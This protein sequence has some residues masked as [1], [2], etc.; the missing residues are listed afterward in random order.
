MRKLVKRQVHC[1]MWT[2]LQLL[3]LLGGAAEAQIS[4]VGLSA[5][6]SQHFADENLIFYVPGVADTFASALAAGDFNGDGADDL[7]TGVPSHDNLG[8]GH[9]D[10]GIVVVRYGASRT[11][12][13]SGLATT[14]LSQV[15]GGEPDPAEDGDAFGWA[16][17]SCDFN[18]DGFD[19]LA[20]G[21]R[22]E[23]VGSAVDAGAVEIYYGGPSGLASVAEQ[24]LT[25]NSNGIPGTAETNDQF[26]MALGC[27][28]LDFDG[29]G[30]LAIG[31]PTETFEHS[32]G[33]IVGAGTVALIYGGPGGLT[34]ARTHSF[35]ED[36]LLPSDH[37]ACGE[38]FGFAL[39]FG[40]FNSDLYDDLVIGA[41]GERIDGSCAPGTGVGGFAYIQGGAGD[42]VAIQLM[43]TSS[44]WGEPPEIGDHVGYTLAAG[45]FDGDLN[46][47]LAVGVPFEDFSIPVIPDAGEV[48]VLYFEGGFPARHQIWYEEEVYGAGTSEGVD[49]FGL[50]LAAA[51][52]DRDGFSD[53]AI[54]HPGE[55]VIATDD[56]ALTVV[57]GS[58]DGLIVSRIRLFVEGNAGLPGPVTQS[59]RTFAAALAAGDFDGDGAADLAIGA[60]LENSA[61]LFDTGAEVV[62]Y[63]SLFCDGFE[64]GTL[65]SWPGEV[66]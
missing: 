46:C 21:V 31:A 4:S 13:R 49:H 37:P 35:N 2:A 50:T 61:T 17:A 60:P 44:A 43:Q 55:D 34:G 28:D 11:G 58:P 26:G 25:Q 36:A 64:A 1:R 51:D 65:S 24:F 7:A 6:R 27:G 32:G 29:F 66:P 12:L 63:G 56:G 15:T 40:D 5:V 53:L 57:M 33:D 52:F 9:P 3:L 23:D 39:V 54:G 38:L 19:D 18:G 14:V 62:L 45:D 10:S 42:G 30:D 16:L 8:A 22:L 48:A 59:L 20:V 41:P 47:D